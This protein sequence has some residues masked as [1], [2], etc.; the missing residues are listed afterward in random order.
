MLGVLA[1]TQLE[2]LAA[3]NTQSCANTMHMQRTI[4]RSVHSARKFVD[5]VR[6]RVEGGRGGSGI[7]SF[8]S[9][10]NVK[11]RPIGGHGG[12]GGDVVIEASASVQDLTLQSRVVRGR[13]GSSAAGKGNNGRAGATRKLVV[14]VGT[15]VKEVSRTYDLAGTDDDYAYSPADVAEEDGS[16]QAGGGRGAELLNTTRAVVSGAQGGGVWADKSALQAVSDEVT[17]LSAARASS[18]SATHGLEEGTGPGLVRL[19]RAGVPYVETVR[20]LADLDAPGQSLTV[21]RG[22]TGGAGNKGVN[23]TYSEQVKGHGMRPHIRG[24]APEVRTIELELKSIADV[25]LV[26]FV[27]AGKSSFLGAVSAAKPLVAAYPFT[28]L[29]PTIGVLHFSDGLQLKVA[30]IPGTA[31]VQYGL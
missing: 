15:V 19:S 25:G 17:T 1:A 24:G 7:I 22:G 2:L 3:R 4:Y 28:T 31:R 30:D 20:V 11:Q 12:R 23:L 13:D 14:P 9:L 5:R 10:D 26:G 29:H 8:Q 27:N 18:V 21:A 6:V 16:A